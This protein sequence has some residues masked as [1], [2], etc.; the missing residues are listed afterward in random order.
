MQIKGIPPKWCNWET[1]RQV[2]ST[3]GKLIEVDRQSLFSSFFA[4]V[5]VKIKCRDPAS[6]PQ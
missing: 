2:A 5:R 4:M 3:L 1:L 6:I